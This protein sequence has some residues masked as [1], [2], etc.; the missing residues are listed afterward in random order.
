M[1]TNVLSVDEAPLVNG[2]GQITRRTERRV[3]PPTVELGVFKDVCTPSRTTRGDRTR[4]PKYLR[5]YS[6]VLGLISHRRGERT[7]GKDRG[8]VHV[9]TDSMNF[10]SVVISNK[11][12]TSGRN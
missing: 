11:T 6:R 12:R 2:P 10:K 4:R 1:T 8:G 9:S 7:K 5:F 3:T